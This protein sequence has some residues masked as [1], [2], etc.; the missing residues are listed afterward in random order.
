[1]RVNYDAILV[2][3]N[4]AKAEH[5]EYKQ[6][7]AKYCCEGMQ[8]NY[9]KA[10]FFGNFDSVYQT[11]NK[12]NMGRVHIDQ[13]EGDVDVFEIPIKYCPFCREEIEC[14]EHKR[15]KKVIT[16]FISTY[17]KRKKTRF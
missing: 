13:Y 17:N 11:D 1:M 7:S 8:N 12:V 3:E 15:Y 5:W 2:G 16:Q 10:I 4:R 9:G 6:V 14:V